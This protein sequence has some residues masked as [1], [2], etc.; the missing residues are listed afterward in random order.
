MA[1]RLLLAFLVTIF[2]F[3]YVTLGDFSWLS[4]KGTIAIFHDL[5]SEEMRFVASPAFKD[6]TTY[7]IFFLALAFFASIRN[8]GHF[9]FHNA[10]YILVTLCVSIFLCAFISGSFD[11]L[12]G[13]LG[14]E[15]RL[16]SI[17]VTSI[18][19]L[20]SYNPSE[21]NFHLPSLLSRSFWLPY[22]IILVTTTFFCIT[23][24]TKSFSWLHDTSAES[25]LLR[26]I[27]LLSIAIFTIP[28]CTIFKNK[29][30]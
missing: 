1:I 20:I 29:T 30:D 9:I 28:A 6:L 26:F 24:A 25:L 7:F 3:S 13:F 17:I 23:I 11:E 10:H 22:Y 16:V 8:L 2:I 21:K 18:F 12:F 19:L 27:L 5:D 15:M 4:P 14:Q